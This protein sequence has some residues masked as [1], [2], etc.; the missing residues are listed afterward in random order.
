MLG[1]RPA[2]QKTRGGR[3]KIINDGGG[4][5]Y[6]PARIQP[7]GSIIVLPQ[8]RA[9]RSHRESTR[10]S[11][12][13]PEQTATY[14]SEYWIAVYSLLVANHEEAL[15]SV[16]GL[17]LPADCDINLIRSGLDTLRERL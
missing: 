4:L 3:Q 11:P 12:P 2:G 14:E 9:L 7:L 17:T 13:N 10:V 8:N 15:G 6:P 1:G 5:T 16:E